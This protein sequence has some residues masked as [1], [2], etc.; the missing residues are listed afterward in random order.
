MIKSFGKYIVSKISGSI[1]GKVLKYSLW[2]SLFFFGPGAVVATVGVPTL[3]VVAITA[4]SGIVEYSA[5]KV[6]GNIL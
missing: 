6:I 4:H 2:S 5:G 3:A 1:V